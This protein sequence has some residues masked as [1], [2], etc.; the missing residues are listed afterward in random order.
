MKKQDR[1]FPRGRPVLLLL[2]I[3]WGAWFNVRRNR[4]DE[5]GGSF[6]YS[7]LLQRTAGDGNVLSV[8]SAIADHDAS[9]ALWTDRIMLL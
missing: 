7:V 9:Q 8:D 1:L 2:T 3:Y 4:H 6:L 5:W